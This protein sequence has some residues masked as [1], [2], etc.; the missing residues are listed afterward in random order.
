MFERLTGRRSEEEEDRMK[1]ATADEVFDLMDA[2]V[3]SAAL[4]AALELGL[5]WLLAE[6]PLEAPAVGEALGIP[7]SRCRYWLQLLGTMGLIE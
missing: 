1:P 3:T 7:P 5:F 6:Q 4:N 2:Y